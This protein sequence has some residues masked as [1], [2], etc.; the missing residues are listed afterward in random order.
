[1]HAT[2]EYMNDGMV[3]M[4]V[5]ESRRELG[6]NYQA[7]IKSHFGSLLCVC[8]LIWSSDGVGELIAAERR[9]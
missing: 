3:S 4:E 1:M 7:V 9:M 5:W 6:M 8:A 2:G